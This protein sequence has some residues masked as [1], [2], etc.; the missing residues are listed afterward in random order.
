MIFNKGNKW[1]LEALKPGS[2]LYS[3]PLL[4]SFFQT[5]FIS[6]RGE[7]IKYRASVMMIILAFYPFLKLI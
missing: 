3:G 1:V 6:G 2:H 4:P 7:I 5:M